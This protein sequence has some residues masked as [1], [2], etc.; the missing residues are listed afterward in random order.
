MIRDKPFVWVTW[1]K[2]LVGGDD[3]C[4]WQ[5]WYKVHNQ[6]YNKMPN[7]FD[8]VDWNIKHTR[9]LRETRV[10][11]AANPLW[12]MKTEGQN[13][14]K[15]DWPLDH[16]HSG[17]IKAVISGKPDLIAHG[18]D[19]KNAVIIDAKTGKGRASDRVQVLL[20]M[21]LYPLATGNPVQFSGV[22]QYKDRED[23]LPA[24]MVSPDFKEAVDFWMNIVLSDDEPVAIPSKTECN[25]CDIAD[26]PVRFKE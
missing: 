10:K 13:S 21:Y 20:Y 8:S 22:V 2:G 14:F 15:M 1:L 19:G 23:Q 18:R 9:L 16:F 26:C 3:S 4:E 12:D 25:F 11:W 24:F 7:D 17:E 5:I 6:D